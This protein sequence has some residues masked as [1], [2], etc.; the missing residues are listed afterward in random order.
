MT[1]LHRGYPDIRPHELVAHLLRHTGQSG[2]RSVDT[3]SLLDYLKLTH[4]RFSFGRELPGEVKKGCPGGTPRALLSL[5]DRLVAT[6]SSLDECA[7]RWSLLHEMAHYVLP[8]HDHAVYV[9]DDAGLGAAS[10]LVME[11]E[12][13]ELAADLLFLG[14]TFTTE[15]NSRA[16]SAATVR[17]LALKY[18]ASCE[19][20][21]RRLVQK[22]FRPAMLAVFHRQEDAPGAGDP[23]SP[24]WTVR[25]CVASP[26]F[27]SRHYARIRGAAPPEAV[28][29]VTAPGRD[30]AD[31]YLAEVRIPHPPDTEAVFR[32]EYFSSGHDIF[33][34]LL[35]SGGNARRRPP[36]SGS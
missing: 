17:D 14:D 29:A 31:S 24:K 26:G 20:A 23:S 25:C 5:P 12:A 10:R 16:V 33:C 1:A 9:C 15:A 4:A 13:N 19:A 27:Q 8:G 2:R 30:I 11:R 3:R 7:T 35:P 32:A 6:D 34:L 22:S 21:A 18:M 36:S 28:S